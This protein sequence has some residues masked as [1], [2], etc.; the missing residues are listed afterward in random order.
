MAK[1]KIKKELGREKD[2]SLVDTH[3]LTPKHE[4]GQY[5]DG[6]VVL[7]DPVEHMKEHGTYREREKDLEVIKSLIDD[8]RQVMKLVMKI[9]NQLLAYTRDVDKM[10]EITK[11]WLEEQ[12]QSVKEELKTR[13]KHIVK[14]IKE[15]AKIDKLTAATLSV[16]GCGPITVANMLTYIDLEKARHASSLWA[17]TGLDKPS[18]E[19]YEKNVAGGG[20]K[21]LRTALYVFAC[22]QI[23]SPGSAYREVYDRTKTRLENS[24]KITKSKN[25]KGKWIECA[26]KDTKPS[27]RHGAAIRAIIKHFLADYW[28]VGRTIKGL[29]TD[30]LY[31]EAVLKGNHRTIMPEE[32][33]WKYVNNSKEP[34]EKKR[35]TV[36][37]KTK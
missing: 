30:P 14:V 34:K 35:V 9:Q 32:R 19:R 36:L 15:Y 24:D 8:R 26:W 6:N 37:K 3:R 29:P 17:Y 13:E 18:Y 10:N 25:T 27:H 31:A 23:K 33:G 11:N 21:T 16:K 20:N 7:S 12:L 1:E 5:I 28:M 2:F 22:V 4:G